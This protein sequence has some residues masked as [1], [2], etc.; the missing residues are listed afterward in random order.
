MRSG[1]RLEIQAYGSVDIR[2]YLRK[3]VIKANTPVKR[4]RAT[5]CLTHALLSTRLI[6]GLDFS[7]YFV[8]FL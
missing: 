7:S 2:A 1:R 3:R 8:V 6:L 4:V 5:A